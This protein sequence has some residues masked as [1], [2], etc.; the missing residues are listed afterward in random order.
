MAFAG[1]TSPSCRTCASDRPS[2]SS[3]VRHA[4][5]SSTWRSKTR[6]TFGCVTSRARRTS[7]RRRSSRSDAEAMGSASTL[8]ATR[9]PSSRSDAAKTTPMPPRPISTSSRYRSPRTV[10][11]RS[12]SVRGLSPGASAFEAMCTSCV[13]PTGSAPAA[14]AGAMTCRSA[15]FATGETCCLARAGPSSRQTSC[16]HVAVWMLR[17]PVSVCVVSTHLAARAL[18]S[19]TPGSAASHNLGATAAGPP[20]AANVAHSPSPNAPTVACPSATPPRRTS[21]CVGSRSRQVSPSRSMA[22]S[23]SRAVETAAAEASVG[24]SSL[25]A[26]KTACSVPPCRLAMVP[27]WRKTI[28]VVSVWNRP[29]STV[30]SSGS[31]AP[32]SSSKS[33]S[34]AERIATDRRFRSSAVPALASSSSTTC[35]GR[36]RPRRPR[37]C[38][39]SACSSTFTCSRWLASRT[40]ASRSRISSFWRW[41]TSRLRTRASSSSSWNGL[42]R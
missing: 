23:S 42:V 17:G 22:S 25:G 29:K 38:S 8:S 24:E 34:S 35:G 4:R 20:M 33:H 16:D 32:A 1:T 37:R 30:R 7:R 15:L 5:P 13:S 27:P 36:N 14:P 21:A 12:A 26:P 39:A 19:T 9:S 40:S 28:S 2:T 11:M 31:T 41:M 10:P 6:H 18:T 3:I